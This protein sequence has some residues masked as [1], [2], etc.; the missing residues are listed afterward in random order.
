MSSGTLGNRSRTCYPACDDPARRFRRIRLSGKFPK[1][2]F[3]G[4][5]WDIEWSHPIV[6]SLNG[7]DGSRHRLW[8]AEVTGRHR[9]GRMRKCEGKLQLW[10]RTRTLQALLPP[11][12]HRLAELEF[13]VRFASCGVRREACLVAKKMLYL[14]WNLVQAVGTSI[15][16]LSALLGFEHCKWCFTV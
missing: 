5:V 13:V 3:T 7:R 11:S 15:V 10:W 14:A 8:P 12:L 1:E 9:A 4:I 16:V 2:K 6:S